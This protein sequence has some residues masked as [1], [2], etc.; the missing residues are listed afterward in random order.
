MKEKPW[1]ISQ[2]K[3]AYLF[4]PRV[5]HPRAGIF[6]KW[7]AP[8]GPSPLFQECPSPSKGISQH[9]QF[10]FLFFLKIVIPGT[11]ISWVTVRY[12]NKIFKKTN[13]GVLLFKMPNCRFVEEIGVSIVGRKV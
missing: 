1:I 8:T 4:T 12:Q 7:W 6:P 9:K 10:S 3:L 5:I 13:V 11:S 2:A